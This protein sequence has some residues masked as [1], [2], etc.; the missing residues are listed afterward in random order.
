MEV[1]ELIIKATATVI[2]SDTGGSGL[3]GPVASYVQNAC[4]LKP[5]IFIPA[6]PLLCGKY[7]MQQ[8]ICF[9]ITALMEQI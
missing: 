8:S 2:W 7:K 6:Q 9:N 5:L 1:Y 4:K 3:F